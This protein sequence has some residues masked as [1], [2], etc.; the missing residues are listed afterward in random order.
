MNGLND[1]QYQDVLRLLGKSTN[2]SF[3]FGTISSLD[4]AKNLAKVRIEPYD[5]ETGW[6]KAM[7]GFFPRKEPGEEV[8]VG[9]IRGSQSCQFVILGTLG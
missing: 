9:V 7:A 8:L 6:C 3:L 4:N 5:F 1:A 2:S